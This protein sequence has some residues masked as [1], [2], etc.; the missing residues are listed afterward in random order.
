MGR[1]EKNTLR[2]D[3]WTKEMTT[4]DMKKFISTVWED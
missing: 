4:D 2:I 3:L 1:Q